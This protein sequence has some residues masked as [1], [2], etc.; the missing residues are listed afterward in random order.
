MIKRL[1]TIIL[2][3]M[4][5]ISCNPKAEKNNPMLNLIP[6]DS[7]IIIQINDL[8]YIKNFINNN[9][10]FS[11]TNFAQDSLNNLIKGINI[12]QSKNSGLLS[13]SSYGKNNTA[14]TFISNKNY[15]DSLNINNNKSYKYNR[16][17]IF[18][19]GDYFK[20]YLGNTVI[21]STS[22]IIIENTIRNY[23]SGKR[24]INNL[25]FYDL[26]LSSN[27][28]EPINIFTDSELDEFSKEYFRSIEFYPIINT[29]WKSYDLSKSNNDIRLTGITRINDSIKSKLSILKN[30]NPKS[31][32]SDRLIPN[33]FKSF[34]SITISDSNL[35]LKNYQDYLTQINILDELGAFE[36]IEVINEITFLQ[37][38]D[39]SIILSVADLELIDKLSFSESID[40]SKKIFDLEVSKNLNELF[41]LFDKNLNIQYGILIDKFI[42]LGNSKNQLKKIL[43]SFENKRTLNNDI[44]YQKNRENSINKLSFLW[45]ANTK[46]I[47][48]DETF[49]NSVSKKLDTKLYPFISYEGIVDKQ[50]SL[51]NFYIDRVETRESSGNIYNELIVSNTNKITV[52][53]KW[54]K[55]HR[56]NQYDFA[57]QDDEN[58]LYLYSNKGNLFWKKKL[59]SQIIGE[60]QQVDLYKNGRLQMAFRTSDKFFIIDRNGS[61]VKP[62]EISF[63]KSDY[64]NPLSIFDYDNSKNYRFLLSQDNLIKMYDNRGKIVS[65]FNPDEFNADILNPPVHI[66]IKDKDYILLQLKNGELKILNRRGKER[67][68]VN[69][70][71]DFS[72]NNFFSFMDLFTT[73]DINGNLIQIDMN[74]NVVQNS[75]N[76]KENNTIEVRMDNILIHSGNSMNI[77]GKIINLPPGR[78][79][80]PKL[81][82]YKDLL[83]ISIT[84]E[85]ENK[86]YLFNNE[87]DMINGFPL[88]GTNI[89][90]IVDSDNDGKI[91]LISQLDNNSVISYEIN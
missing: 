85:K 57:Y 91:E 33:T 63:K 35:F 78:Y 16:Y 28:N 79:T 49:I 72:N 74:G 82:N 17:N 7:K 23:N 60:I 76:L 10:L 42:V 54:L 11:Q 20:T 62:F 27:K 55:N 69:K 14:I 52:P 38:D 21:S 5:F 32:E 1:E 46:Q 80:K 64:I 48:D 77:N 6:N 8:G 70:N 19:E 73:T 39:K 65:G 12:D 67:I 26:I 44:Y 61:I 45:L 59:S 2:L 90:D 81:F 9:Q 24:G 18:Q 31:L 43:T 34:L 41:G 3:I 87:G 68:S 50:L 86:I 51:L 88:K 56:N 75:Y 4:L 22:D 66:R 25:S 71:I 29:S 47:K 37:D 83:Y 36:E 84:D 30:I 40:Y 15:S 89:V 53:P 58:Y 13:F